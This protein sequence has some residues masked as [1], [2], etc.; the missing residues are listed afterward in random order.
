VLEALAQREEATVQFELA[1]VGAR[2]LGDR[3]LEGQFLGYL[4]LARAKQGRFDEAS[5]CLRLGE[6]LLGEVGDR[7]NRAVLLCQW[8]EA[9][10][11]AGDVSAASDLLEQA[12]LLATE[13]N[14]GVDSELGVLLRTAGETISSAASK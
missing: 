9:E 4:G 8:T 5:Q 11:L 10:C 7:G 1:L 12:R 2:K 13:T 6:R 3:R 14:A